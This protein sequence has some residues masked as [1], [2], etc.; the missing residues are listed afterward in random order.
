MVALY[1]LGMMNILWMVL[2]TILIAA[3]RLLPRR[4]L[5]VAGAAA[6]LL[7]LGTAVAALP[8]LTTP[9]AGMR[10]GDGMQ[11]GKTTEMKSKSTMDAAPGSSV[12]QWPPAVSHSTHRPGGHA[13]GLGSPAQ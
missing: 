8:E 11:M 3:E 10:M 6:L 12:R 1:A 2:L 7:L 13:L 4:G 9:A 5:T